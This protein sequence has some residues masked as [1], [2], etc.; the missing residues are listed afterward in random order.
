MFSRNLA[1]IIGINNYKNGISP[2]K[3]AVNDAKKLVE[4]LR[5]KHNY[6]VWVCLDEAAT[7]SNLNQFIEKT[8]PENVTKDDRLLFYF[9]GHG[10]A[11]NG[12]DGPQGYLIPQDAKQGDTDSYLPMT[13][14]HDALS[15]LKCRHFLGIFDCCFSGAFRWSST[16]DLLTTP[17]VI[18]KERYDRFITDAAWQ[19]LTSSASD[20]KALDNF[21][22]DT[23]RGQVGEHSPFAAALLEALEGEADCYPP[24]KNGKPAGDGVITATE[25]YLYL[26]DRVEIP[27]E[28][29]NL[30][31]TPGIWCL[32]KHDKGEYIFLSPGH[33]LNLPPAP[34]LDE[35][36]NPY[37][38]LESFDEEHSELFFG[39]QALTQQLYQQVC[40][41]P[42]TVVLG[43]SGTGKSS[44]VKAGLIPYIKQL[45]PQWHIF[46]PIRPGESPLR[47]LN[48]IDDIAGLLNQNIWSKFILVIDQGEE[49][50]TLCRNEQERE[51]FLNLLTNLVANYADNLRIIL[52]LRSDFEPQL[53]NTVLEPYWYA[54]R[55]IVPAMTREELRACIQEPASARVMYFEPHN[56]VERLIDEVIQMPGALPLLSFTLSEL[57]LK[58]LKS[59]R[60]G[61]RQDRV[62]TQTDYEQLG[63]VTRSLTQRADA[64]FD[65]LV[66]KDTCY[67]DTI[68]KLMLRMVAVG[69]G[70]LARR[71]VGLSELEYP[72]PENSRIKKVIQ[73]FTDAR[74]LVEGQDSEGKPYVE[75]AHD[76]LVRGWQKL[77]IWKQEEEESL[78]LQRRLTPAAVEWQDVKSREQLSGFQSN[79]K[80]AIN[81]LDRTFNIAE[82]FFN[83]ASKKLIQLWQKRQ[84]RQQLQ[85]EKPA[86][87]LWNANPYLDVLKQKLNS[88]PV[89]FNKLEGE[90]VETSV[91]QKRLNVSWRLR[92]LVSVILGLSGLTIGLLF[93]LRSSQI[94]EAN[95]LRK[96]AEIS[97]SDNQSL[98]GIIDV[99]QAG[100][101]L[102][103]PLL[104]LFPPDTQLKEEIAGTLQKAV[105]TVKENNRLQGYER[106]VRTVVFSPDGKYLATSGDDGTARLWNLQGQ[107]LQR[108]EKHQGSVRTIKFSPD[109]DLLVTAGDDGI[110]RLW[111]LQ[112]KLIQDWNAQQGRLWGIEFSPN[113]DLIASQGNNGTVRLWN[114]QGKLLG[115]LKGHQKSV[116]SLAFLE[117]FGE[118]NLH[119]KLSASPNSQLIASGSDDG[120]IRFWD[121]QGKELNKIV[122]HQI[123]VS[124][125]SFSS[126]NQLLVSAGEDSFVR[127]WNVASKQMIE[128]WNTE[129]GKLWGIAFSPN[130]QQLATAGGDG[131]VRIW[132]LQGEELEKFVAHK[133]PVRSVSFSPDGQQLASS[134]DDTMVR[135]WDLQGK[136]SQ[137]FTNSNFA[138]Q[139]VSNSFDLSNDG[140]KVVTGGQDGIIRLW[141][142]QSNGLLKSFPTSS[143][144]IKS[145]ALS[146]DETQIVTGHEDGTIRLWN[147]QGKLLA[148]P[149][150]TN[151][152]SVTSVNLSFDNQQIVS[153]HEDGNLF[154]WNLASRTQSKPF[155]GHL[156]KVNSVDFRRDGQQIVS[157]SEDG[158]IR[159]WNLQSKWTRIFQI[160]GPEITSAEFASD[161]QKI[162]SSDSEGRILIWNLKTSEQ[163]PLATWNTK[164]SAIQ[165]ISLNF[166]SNFSSNS[167]SQLLTTVGSDGSVKTWKIQSSEQLIE[168]ACDWSQDYLRNNKNLGNNHLCD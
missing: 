162:I 66:K 151:S 159:L 29:S 124:S 99:L 73:H 98:D 110:V 138:N 18:H 8:L 133:G 145:V 129:Q 139:N 70:E 43:A 150:K 20:Q 87:Y 94:R 40:E 89:W 127:V 109:G 167:D 115:E 142:L 93:F 22:L 120:T 33:E 102:K 65:N 160:Y 5:E 135:I 100:N 125:L 107:E 68:R 117:S 103:Q 97:L 122:G 155:T 7:L 113:G 148:Q 111:N 78:I 12:D 13:K 91:L 62:I 119:P 58:Y 118:E 126:D 30:R 81:G 106:P 130:N 31:Q 37:R 72:E 85:R 41:Q 95:T 59:V 114:L 163:L 11:L 156:G 123:S 47:A 128:E 32:N 9:A 52:T 121:F 34:P 69:G 82:I 21:K 165:N 104:R 1:F 25:L 44:L 23:E 112:G 49:L 17:E 108:F 158:T 6:Q 154:T 79:I 140:Q 147:R 38:G 134:S 153:G 57:Y 116:K 48:N 74:L 75:P 56:L 63:G 86:Q 15:N 24:A 27:T 168:Q 131:S 53:S 4:I 101:L 161:S 80:L 92:F 105:Y 67:S 36:K 3:T 14:L 2:L 141:N 166:S 77:L 10:V 35:S 19:I 26:R 76:A 64:E 45:N 61:T 60:E 149:F 143:S 39:R 42:L 146:R 144:S 46:S 84:N 132:N 157:G 96:S 28:K 54:S 50:F 90:F 83:T 136:E 137:K 152:G 164:Q 71:R 16:R 55:F 88:E 51:D